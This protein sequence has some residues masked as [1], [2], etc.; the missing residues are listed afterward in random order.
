MYSTLARLERDGLTAG[1]GVEKGEGA[2]RRVYAITADGVHELDAWLSRAS[3][4]GGR[5]SELFTRV[6]LAIVSGR[7]AEEVLAVQ[8]A[9]YL[10]RMREITASRHDGDAIDRLAGD[11]EMAH[12]EA[13]LRWVELAG[14]RLEGLAA[15]VGPHP[16]A[17]HGW[18][19]EGLPVPE[20]L[21]ANS[22]A[23]GPQSGDLGPPPRHPGGISL[24]PGHPLAGLESISLNQE[25]GHVE[26]ATTAGQTVRVPSGELPG[27]RGVSRATFAVRTSTFRGD[28][29]SRRRPILVSNRDGR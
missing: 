18:P 26:I 16:G 11:F 3:F 12:L 28:L 8:R 2:D 23:A 13:D 20:R 19:R 5:P 10:A 29:G 22:D 17:I 27:P 14:T 24:P 7:P 25:T 15:E 6:V 9:A 4:P 21:H 1:A